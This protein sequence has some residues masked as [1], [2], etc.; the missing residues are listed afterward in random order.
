MVLVLSEQLD[1]AKKPSSNFFS[2]E[3]ECVS[4]KF[5]LSTHLLKKSDIVSHIY[6]SY[7]FSGG[8]FN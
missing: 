5:H 7:L 3:Y 2:L 1:F 6:L 8:S 4:S